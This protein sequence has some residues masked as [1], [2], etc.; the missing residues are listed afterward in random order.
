MIT[1][2]NKQNQLGSSL[3][4]KQFLLNSIKL[5]SNLTQKDIERSYDIRNKQTNETYVSNQYDKFFRRVI[6]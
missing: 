4:R 5:L 2:K 6:A 3:E 1:T